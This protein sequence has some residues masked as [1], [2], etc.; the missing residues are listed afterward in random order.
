MDFV[1]FL[2][3]RWPD[4]SSRLFTGSVADVLAFRDWMLAESKAP[5]TINRIPGYRSAAG[6][7]RPTRLPAP[8]ST[9]VPPTPPPVTSLCGPASAPVLYMIS[10]FP[11]RSGRSMSDR[12]F[13]RTRPPRTPEIP[14]FTGGFRH[15]G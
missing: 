2:G 8:A 3:I 9:P 11:A 12:V 15:D 7:N 6:G 14:A 1:R 10:T 5:K 4:E 13:P